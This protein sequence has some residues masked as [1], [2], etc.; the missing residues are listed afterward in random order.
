MISNYANVQ[1]KERPLSSDPSVPSTYVYMNLIS[2]IKGL[3]YFHEIPYAGFSIVME[4]MKF[5]IKI[6]SMAIIIYL[7]KLGNTNRNF[8]TS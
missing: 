7:Q 6:D 3:Q 1:S 8:H 2:I 5:F 4:Q